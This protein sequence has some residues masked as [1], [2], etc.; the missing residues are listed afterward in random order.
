M[1][2]HVQLLGSVE[3]STAGQTTTVIS[4]SAK[5]VTA[6]NTIV[7]GWGG[8]YDITPSSVTDNLGNTYTRVE[9]TRV[10]LNTADLWYA[11]VT[12]AGSITTITVSHASTQYVT[13]IAS[14]FSSVGAF[15]EAG[16]G[17]TGSSTTTTWMT[18][19]TIPAN[20]L[21]VGASFTNNARIHTAGSASGAP[22]TSITKAGQVD[23]SSGAIS[24]TYALAGGSE[25]TAFTGTTTLDTTN[26]WAG[27]GA[28]FGASAITWTTPADTVS[29]S[30]TPQLQF[31]SPASAVA[32]HFYMELDTA[33][34]FDTG[35][36]RTY[37]SSVTQT[38]W[39]YWDGDSWEAMPAAGLASTYAGNEV[40]YTVTSA[41]AS[42]TWYRRVR[43]GTLV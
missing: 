43:A 28:V 31:D 32:Q 14:E 8:A 16:A 27:V 41:L 18:S 19:K 33:N 11:P 42:A 6:G 15:S 13:A 36:L 35:N 17:T 7:V 23:G 10:N 2:S 22:S 24:L 4:P 9:R 37:D 26:G 12:A 1:A 5:S 29:M 30:T 3:N 39:A 38:N 21:A 20:G 34:T 40:R 25:V